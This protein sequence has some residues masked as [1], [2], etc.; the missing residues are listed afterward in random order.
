MANGVRAVIFDVS[1]TVLDYG[2]RGPA[3]AFVE[4][5]R[6]NGME[7]TEDEARRPMGTSKRDHIR[8]VLS[9]PGVAARWSGPS[10]DELY[11]QFVP[12]QVEVLRDFC[13]VI[14]GVV[15][16]TR[17]LRERRIPFANTTGFDSEMI[18]D[19]MRVAEEQ[20]YKPDIWVTPDMVGGGRPAPWMAYHAARHMGVYP[21]SNV[22]KVGDT[23]A[24]IEEANSAGMWAV[25]VVRHGNEMG[26]SQAVLNA[27]PRSESGA[28]LAAARARLAARKPHY[29][30]D[31]TADLIP[32][33]DAI[34]WRISRGERP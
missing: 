15:E 8:A 31:A 21:M 13:D 9:D 7:I 27:L 26:L 32:V 2:S 18:G 11:E 28:R 22:V 20:G 10:T 1:G 33:L 24:D 6:R 14:P 4:L 12:L 5:F 29:I 25:S 17:E 23:F 19:L 34:S 30:V 3:A 16:V